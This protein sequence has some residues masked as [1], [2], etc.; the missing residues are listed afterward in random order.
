MQKPLLHP[1]FLVHI[2]IPGDYICLMSHSFKKI[3][4]Q[5]KLVYNR[6]DSES[7]SRKLT[8]LQQLASVP[9]G[10]EKILGQYHEILLFMAAHPSDARER[11]SVVAEQKRIAGYLKK[12]PRVFKERLTNSGLPYA[13]V[14][15]RFSHDMNNWLL[16]HQQ[17]HVKLEEFADPVLPLNDVLK[18]TLPA[19][20]RTDTTAGLSN[21]D[22]L[23][24]LGV[25]ADKQ[26]P[27]LINEISRLNETP[28]IKDQLFEAL[29]IYTRVTPVDEHLC[30]QGNHLKNRTPFYHD[31]IIKKFDHVQL[32]NTKLPEA[33]F[34]NEVEKKQAVQVVRNAFLL[35]ARETDPSTY[36]DINSFRLYELERGIAVAIYG[37]VPERQL[38]LESYIG[39]TLFRNGYPAAYGGG[40]V[41]GKRSHFGINIFE[42]FRGG[43]SGYMMCQLL[44]VYRQVFGVDYFEVEPYQYGLDNPEGIASGAFWFYYRFG[45]RPLDKT[46]HHLADKEYQKI[47][48]KKGYHSS[49]K[50]LLRFTESNIALQLGKGIPLTAYEITLKLR[51]LINNTYKGNRIL[52]EKEMVERFLEQC[53]PG[54][55]FDDQQRKVLTEMAMMAA[56]LKTEGAEK[57]ALLTK[58]IQLKPLDPYRYQQVLLSLLS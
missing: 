28:F 15:T 17:L 29:N 8:L 2:V 23:E 39:Y 6:F 49:E 41:F 47:T 12:K 57:M 31:D 36:M 20:E 54:I 24:T 10:D 1:V 52:A 42:W 58:A 50:T 3:I 9:L 25:K 14:V 38:P 22:L 4:N 26:L 27:F 7:K 19:I 44:R 46:L 33:V 40:W 45:F 51:Q 48:G 5:L 13:P 43:E 53:E 21:A 30:L 34:M 18:F 55:A 32:L 35:T 11:K 16:S 56:A 37:M